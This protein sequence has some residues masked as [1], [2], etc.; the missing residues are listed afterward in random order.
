MNKRQ[1][2]CPITYSPIELHEKYSGQGLRRLSPALKKLVDFPYSAEQQI[3]EAQKRADKMS[4]QGVQPKL[5]ARLN[6]KIQGFEICDG[7]GT[8]ILK[9]QNKAYPELPENEDL[10]MRLAASV[11]G[12]PLHGL[13]YSVDGRFTYFIKRFDRIAHG[14]KVPVEDFAQLAGLARDTKYEYSMEKLIPVI[15]KFCTF[16][17]MEKSKLF[18]RVIFNYLIGNEDMHLKNYSL[19]TRNEFTELAPVYDFI[20]TTIA[21]GNA[22]EQIAL[23][24]NGKKNKLTRNDIVEYY[25]VERL[26]LNIVVVDDIL[27]R[28]RKA[29]PLWKNLIEVSFLS[30]QAKKEYQLV[31]MERLK[32][33]KLEG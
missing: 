21:I 16:P 18:T 4:I 13:L 6:T 8:Y 11:M 9:P 19:I 22:S 1:H 10:S 26:G 12:A 5:S 30:E 31:L 29:V 32:V 17:A 14:N 20:N 3:R 7:G 27:N 2:V 33:L 23:S 24:L 15:D 28:F 25:G